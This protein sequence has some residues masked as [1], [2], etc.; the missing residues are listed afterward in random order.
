MSKSDFIKLWTPDKIQPPM[1]GSSG[2]SYWRYDPE[3]IFPH[4][5]DISVGAPYSQDPWSV[6]G[7][8][9]TYSPSA[10]G[11]SRT[12]DG[13]T[14]RF[15]KFVD[16]GEVG[17][18]EYP[19][20]DPPEQATLE[21]EY[22]LEWNTA[23]QSADVVVNNNG[24]VSAASGSVTIIN[25]GANFIEWRRTIVVGV[26]NVEYDSRRDFVGEITASD[27]PAEVPAGDLIAAQISQVLR[28]KLWMDNSDDSVG[29][30]NVSVGNNSSSN[31]STNGAYKFRIAAFSSNLLPDA[32]LKAKFSVAEFQSAPQS[33]NTE[34]LN[35]APGDGGADELGFIN[36]ANLGFGD[37]GWTRSFGS[38][39]TWGS[40]TVADNYGQIRVDLLDPPARDLSGSLQ[41][42]LPKTVSGYPPAGEVDSTVTLSLDSGGKS[43][44][45]EYTA[46]RRTYWE[47]PYDP[48]TGEPLP[49][50]PDEGEGEFLVYYGNPTLLVGGSVVSGTTFGFR[51]K[52]RYPYVAL[53][54]LS[55][56]TRYRTERE[57]Y[58]GVNSAGEE[59]E[60]RSTRVIAGPFAQGQN[61]ALRV[62]TEMWDEH[63]LEPYVVSQHEH[64]LTDNFS[65]SRYAATAENTFTG[66]T[67]QPSRR[68]FRPVLYYS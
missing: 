53:G 15:R 44:V 34:F 49:G 41:V 63:F 9:K 43:D 33:V 18:G 28:Q 52:R 7:R 67:G 4:F 11:H 47:P 22:S 38:N 65:T 31:L 10:W 45:I 23:T 5:P 51:V 40:S 61:A 59:V 21:I 3:F 50:S 66:M 30:L 2:A 42:R 13:V 27:L 32:T 39:V 20:E 29:W 54:F 56:G 58:S 1:F 8:R 37:M 26:I 14:R 46:P 16:S 36:P 35:P 24:G 6:V 60:S 48:D 64:A 19:E 62:E 57:T 12:Y 68:I 17:P 25:Q 55:E